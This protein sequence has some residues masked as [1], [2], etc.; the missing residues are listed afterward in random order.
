MTHRLIVNGELL[1]NG[2]V[3]EGWY[4]ESFSYGEVVRALTEMSGDITLR[5][6]SGGGSAVDGIGIYNALRARA[7]LGDTI[8]VFVDGIAA[9]AAS[10]I[11][12]AG[13]EIV[14]RAGAL[15]MIHNGSAM[16]WGNKESH[17]K[18]IKAL[19]RF[20][21]QAAR[22]Y[23]KRSKEKRESVA[24]MMT[25]ET[26]MTGEEAVAK[27]FADRDDSE[28]AVEAA[29]FDYRLYAHAPQHLVA[30]STPLQ[31]IH[32][33]PAGRNGMTNRA[34]AAAAPVSQRDETMANDKPTGAATPQP[35]TADTLRAQHGDIIAQIEA[36]A[37]N[38]AAQAERVRIT[39]IDEHAAGL[40][41][42]E[43]VVKELKADASVTADA[44]AARLLAASKAGIAERMTALGKMDAA[45][46][47]VRSTP[48]NGT[49]G[50]PVTASTPEGWE[51]EWKA[52]AKLQ[53]EFPTVAAYIATMKREAA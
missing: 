7:E 26:W 37:A 31:P 43:A 41:G 14:M 2:Y 27:G 21:V 30:L 16:T 38:A 20:D 12:M 24:E 23:A 5:I 1:L 6:N 34:E 42:V 39:A 45:A 11:A 18:T 36:N 10:V 25:A 50:K 3:G 44:A 17:A 19:E 40:V 47:G 49:D 48:S 35:V 28:P 13:D 33:D 29:A 51:A 53:A 4:G 46:E 52:D 15:M 32:A 9:S 8:T 22:I